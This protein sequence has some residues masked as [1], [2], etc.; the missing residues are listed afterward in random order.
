M[1]TVTCSVSDTAGN[2]ASSGTDTATKDIIKPTVS[3]IT[4]ATGDESVTEAD[5][6]VD[7]FVATIV[8][9]EANA[10]DTGTTPTVAFDPTLGSTLTNCAG[11]F[12]GSGDTTYTY[13][14]DVADA[15]IE[16]A[17]IDIDVSGA[18]DTAGNTMDADTTSAIDEFDVDTKAPT[19]STIGAF[20]PVGGTET[21][22]YI[23]GTNTGFTQKF[24]TP[25]SNFAGTAHLYIGGVEFDTPITVAVDAGDTEF[26]LT[27]DATSITGLG[28]DA[29]KALTVVIVDTAGNVGAASAASNITKDT[30]DPTFDSVALG[31]D[32]YVNISD[33]ASGVDIVIATTGTEDGR[34][35]S[36]TITDVDSVHSVG[37]VTTHLVI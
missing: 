16:S 32:E 17:D 31:A 3:S 22:L 33:T 2:A 7:T 26:T 24:T 10:M 5:I 18:K 35:V 13:T 28:I 4:L 15:N 27:G 1:L 29:A 19:A 36:C 8:F 20:A 37:P 12:S 34:T 25:A 30:V 23:N 6:G 9:T 14:C 11:V 21:A